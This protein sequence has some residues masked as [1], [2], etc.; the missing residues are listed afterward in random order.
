[1]FVAF[2]MQSKHYC[3]IQ[4]QF[5]LDKET[6]KYS[7]VKYFNISIFS[8]SQKPCNILA[9][10]NIALYIKKLMGRSRHKHTCRMTSKILLSLSYK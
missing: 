9:F 4:P 7:K 2:Q 5:P 3:R 6:L 10:S 8:R 1:M